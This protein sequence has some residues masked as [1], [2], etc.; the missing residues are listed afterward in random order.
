MTF[1]DVATAE[2]WIHTQDPVPVV[3]G[4]V[5]DPPPGPGVGPGTAAAR[6]GGFPRSALLTGTL[7]VAALVELTAIDRVEV[8]G[9]TPADPAALLDTNDFVR[10]IWHGAELVLSVM[11]AAGGRLVP[12]ETRHP[13]PCCADHA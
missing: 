2:H 5:F 4:T 6:G 13:T 7:T 10:P 8:L 11:P 1:A 3:A 12:F 9:G